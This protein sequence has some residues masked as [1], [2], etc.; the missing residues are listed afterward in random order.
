MRGKEVVAVQTVVLTVDHYA[1]IVSL[2]TKQR[3]DL[4]KKLATGLFIL[5]WD[6]E[7]HEFDLTY[8]G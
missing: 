5:V 3:N 1:W 7:R 4:L 2:T 8:V 6:A